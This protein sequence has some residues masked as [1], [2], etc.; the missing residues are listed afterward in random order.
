MMQDLLGTRTAA[1]LNLAAQVLLLAGLLVGF[2]LARRKRFDQHANVQT[3]MVLLNLVLIFAVMIPS[4]AAYVVAGGSTTGTVAQLMIGHGMLGIVVQLF[5]LYLVLRM[6]TRFIPRRFRIGNIQLAMRTTLAVW[7][8]LVLLGIGIYVE[9]Y[10]NQRAVVSAPLLEM[11]QLGADL[12]V[13]AFELEDAAARGSVPAITRHAEHLINLIEGKEGLHYGDNNI[14]GHLEDPGDGIGLLAR[15]DTVAAAANTPA[16]L[17]QRDV[18]RG[19]LEQIV[20]QSVELLGEPVP[21]EVREPI[22]DILGLARQANV[23]GVAQI[24][25]AARETGVTEAASLLAPDEAGGPGRV[26]IREDQFEFL[27]RA[28]TIPAGTTVEWINDE[29]AKHTATADD[30]LF[31]SGDQDLGVSYEYTFA[32]P[33]TYPYFCRYHGDVDG[34]GMAGT[35]VV[36]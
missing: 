7:T 24:E 36:E 5:A 4:F 27:P 31:D 13:H 3:M 34:V 30:G 9:R 28:I 21:A 35:I 29:R 14:D 33:G 26:T 19:Q 18:V 16:V 15:L 20:A 22:A 1:D 10:L 23:E 12:Y 8:V 6:R 17:D 32:E 2:V 25:L 11:R